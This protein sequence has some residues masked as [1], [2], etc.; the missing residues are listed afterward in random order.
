MYIVLAGVWGCVLPQEMSSLTPTPTMLTSS[1]PLPIYSQLTAL[2]PL[3]TLLPSC[4]CASVRAP[5]PPSFFRPASKVK[6]SLTT[7]LSAEG[8]PDFEVQRLADKLHM[9]IDEQHIDTRRMATAVAQLF[10]P[11][12]L[13]IATD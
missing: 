4:L 12:G 1:L 11:K 7:G 10:G 3:P 6:L 9:A 13:L 8:G 2:I 5:L